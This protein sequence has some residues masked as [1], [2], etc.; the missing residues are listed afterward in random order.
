MW[1]WPMRM[2]NRVKLTRWCSATTFSTCGLAKHNKK[3]LSSV[4]PNVVDFVREDCNCLPALL[5]ALCLTLFDPRRNILGRGG[6][7]QPLQQ[8]VPSVLAPEVAQ[9][10]QAGGRQVQFLSKWCPI[11]SFLHVHNLIFHKCKIALITIK[12]LLFQAIS[13]MTRPGTIKIFNMT[14][15]WLHVM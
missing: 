7:L 6:R 11:L 3:V 13:I 2:V 10:L 15:L 12:F 1:P 8:A 14:L 5:P 9:P 4:R